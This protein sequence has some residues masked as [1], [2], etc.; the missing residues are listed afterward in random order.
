MQAAQPCNYLRKVLGTFRNTT[1]IIYPAS[2][3]H[4]KV[5]E[6]INLLE[7]RLTSRSVSEPGS[8]SMM[9][10]GRHQEILLNHQRDHQNQQQV[11]IIFIRPPLS[12][13]MCLTFSR[14]K[15]S[16]NKTSVKNSFVPRQLGKDTYLITWQFPSLYI[17]VV[18][19]HEFNNA[20]LD[21]SIYCIV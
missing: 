10:A 18:C 17:D 3:L 11:F 12:S 8:R 21:Q 14:Q 13:I 4:K 7:P 15:S 5:V 6:L 20:R 16:Q 1:E 19:I 2:N 9:A